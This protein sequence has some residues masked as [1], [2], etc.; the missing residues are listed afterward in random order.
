MQLRVIKRDVSIRSTLHSLEYLLNTKS[1]G[2][3]VVAVTVRCSV[4]PYVQTCR[5]PCTMGAGVQ[6]FNK[7]R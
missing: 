5:T 7:S 3:N 6:Y 1:F 2:S 4:L